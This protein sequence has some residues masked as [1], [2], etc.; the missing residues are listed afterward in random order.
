[1]AAPERLRADL[2]ARIDARVDHMFSHGLEEEVGQLLASGVP[3]DSHALKAI[4]YRQIVEMLE[5]RWN[6]SDAIEQTKQSS[7]KLAKR[8]LTWLRSLREG[9][10]HRVPPAEH[11]GAEALTG[12]WDHH[13]GGK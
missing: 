11:R 8:Q 1:M 7:R 5:G 12:L 4:G 6:R 3:P 9:S 10:L 2:Y 13:I